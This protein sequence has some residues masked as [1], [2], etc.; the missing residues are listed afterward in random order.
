[1]PLTGGPRAHTVHEQGVNFTM[2]ALTE[3]RCRAMWSGARWIS[4]RRYGR[5]VAGTASPRLY[6][7]AT[8]YRTRG[9]PKVRPEYPGKGIIIVRPKTSEIAGCS[10]KGLPNLGVSSQ[11]RRPWARVDDTAHD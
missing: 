11:Y 7:Q 2:L 3:R 6:G 5:A 1:M 8:A 9:E 4:R 10:S